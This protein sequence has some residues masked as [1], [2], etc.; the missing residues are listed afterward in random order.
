MGS[1]HKNM[2]GQQSVYVYKCRGKQK[3]MEGQQFVIAYKWKVNV[4]ISWDN[5]LLMC[6]SGKLT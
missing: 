5:S 2:M 3:D 6:T 4:K 1:L